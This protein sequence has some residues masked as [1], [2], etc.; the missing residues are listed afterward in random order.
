M[1]E[2]GTGVCMAAVV[3]AVAVVFMMGTTFDDMNVP[4]DVSGGA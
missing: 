1:V 4:P 2:S 3:C